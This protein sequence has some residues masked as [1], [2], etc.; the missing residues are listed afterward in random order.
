VNL[1]RMVR[2]AGAGRE[3]D[4]EK[5]GRTARLGLRFLDDV[6]EVGRWPAPQIT[7]ATRGNRKV[8]LGVMGFAEMLILLG[9]PYASDR[10]V[11]LA[12]ELMRFIAGEARA[13]SAALAAERGVF[14]NW[15]R[16]VHARDGLRLRNA[17][18]TSVAPT[19]TLSIIA[20]TSA[21]IEPLF[22]L[23]YRRAHTLGGPPL[24]E[25]NP[26]F[27]RYARE[28]GLDLG[29]LVPR[30]E[31]AGSLAGIPEVPAEVRELFHTALE[32]A[33]E[34]HLRVQAAFQKHTDNAVSKT[35][36]L[37]HSATAEEIAAVYRRAWELGLKGVTVYRYGSKGEQVLRLGLGETPE[38]REHFARC[39]PHACKL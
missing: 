8:G 11:E 38:E 21:G 37:P 20:G 12:G 5:L 6:V 19:G 9:I 32:I 4:W 10:A 23:A 31:A 15:E 29:Q 34:D 3:V 24:T 1:A 17:T 16:S 33:P 28:R 13:A 39:D 2:Q 35:I 7:A 22:A 25:L 30:L 14:P 36:N 26:L 18:C 27:L